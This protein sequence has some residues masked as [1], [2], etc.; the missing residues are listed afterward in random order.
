[1]IIGLSA[2]LVPILLQFGYQV[3]GRLGGQLAWDSSY[4]YL[5]AGS[6][7]VLS[8]LP[9]C[10]CM[11]ATFP[12]AMAAI[13]RNCPAEQQHSFSFLYLANV[14]GA[15]LGTLIP[16][17]ILIEQMGFQRTL[18]VASSMNALLALTVLV[19]S[20]QSKDAT[21]ADELPAS[22]A[23]RT[24]GAELY[25][26]SSS[27]TLWMLFITGV[28]TMAMEVVWIR[29]FTVY[30]GNVVYA[31]ATILALYLGATY[32][33]SLLYRY[34]SR[35]HDPEDSAGGWVYLGL[36]SLLPL[37]FADPTLPLPFANW[38]AVRAAASIVPFSA[39]LGFL[40]PM[41][42]DHYS[43]G[44]PD[45]AGRAY[46]LNIVGGIL[47]PLLAG[48]LFLPL[49]GDHW[50]LAALS[51][52]LFGIGLLTVFSRSSKV[53]SGRAAF[54][55][56][57]S[58]ATAALLG[59]V[60]AVLTNGYEAILPERMERRDYMATVIAF[61]GPHGKGLLV[62]GIGMT[63]L[64][65]ITKYMV[66]LPLAFLTHPPRNGLVICFGMGTSFRSM[67]S[68][69]IDTTAV[70]LIPSVPQLFGFYHADG[71]E[72]AKSPLAHI[73]IDDGRRYLERSTTQYD[74]ITMDPPPPLTTPSTSL[75]YS[76]E[77]YE[78]VKK[79]LKPGGILQAWLAVGDPGCDRTMATAFS[80]ALQESFPYIRVIPSLNGFGLHFLASMDPIPL[81]SPAELAARMPARA[82]ADF[83]EWGPHRTPE[84]MF[85]E[86]LR[87]VQ[88]IDRVASIIPATPPLQ[89][90][91]PIN[92]YFFMRR[93]LSSNP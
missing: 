87:Y 38:G 70:E 72:I 89:D 30:L 65:P 71:P 68:W 18:Y 79:H 44:D 62:N 49:L 23:E 47:G 82:A 66:H 40:T 25:P 78:V 9:W 92:E 2:M 27:G 83:V 48:F 26:L 43:Q 57:A 5:A 11:G 88:T 15:I 53:V 24:G 34:W 90:D 60:V 63:V 51:V 81:P 7:I 84:E 69:G 75:L 45:R 85:A 56:K 93:E 21:T 86:V 64:T 10:T 19:L 41:L 91:R 14:L 59:I 35:T 74:V 37:V 29:Q 28:C 55:T 80:K 12:M 1:L 20:T 22:V 4:Y 58:F 77:F 31:F 42:V 32:T 39:A 50:A 73:V 17:Y 76:K 46:A 3:I 8:L 13:R 33:G 6:C 61:N 67:L 16:T 54:S 52:P 36:L